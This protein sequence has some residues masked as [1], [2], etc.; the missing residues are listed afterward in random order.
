MNH[1]TI[2]ITNSKRLAKWL[3]LFLI[4]MVSALSIVRSQS[5]PMRLSIHRFMLKAIIV[6]DEPYCCES[7]IT[8]LEKKSEVDIIA[9]CHNGIDALDDRCVKK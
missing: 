5:T 4:L 2:L 7:L 9:V 6:D 1:A 3:L 8:L